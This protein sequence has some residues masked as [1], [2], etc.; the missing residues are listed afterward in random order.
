MNSPA[1]SDRPAC[2]FP[3][4]LHGG[5]YN[6]EQWLDDPGVLAEDFPLMRE[7][8]LSAVTLGVFSWAS[9]EPGEGVF[10][11]GW[12]DE[13]FRRANRHGM[14]VILAT[15]SGGKPNWLALQHEEVR[16][17]TL[18]GRRDPQRGRHNHCLTSPV[19]RRHVR[20]MN[21]RLAERYG[22]D[23]ALALWHVS[24]EYLG[25]C[26]C[27][28]CFAGF[29]E[30]L[31]RRYGS[32]DR[33]NHAYWARFWSHTFTDWEQIRHIDLSIH[34]LS[35]DWKRY[36][37]DLCADFFRAEAEP[38]RALTPH[39]PLTTNFHGIDHYDYFRLAREIDI[40]SWD[41]YPRW[42]ADPST[43]DE[44]AT[45]AEAAFRFDLN[46]C[47]KGGRP[48]LL[49]ECT[50]S[51]LNWQSVSPLRRPG[52]H[53]LS[54]L[55]AVAHGADAVCYFQIRKSRGGSE[56]FHGAV[57]DHAGGTGT[58]TF[59]EV[60]SVGTALQKLGAIAGSRIPARVAIVFDWENF[61]ALEQAET[62]QNAHKDYR[63]TCL[64]HH[65]PF[66]KMGIAVDVIGAGA[67]LS[68]YD[69]VILPMLY[70]LPRGLDE[71]LSA[72]VGQGGT[73]VAT[74]Q[75]G[76]VDETDLCFLGGVPGPLASLLGIWVEEFDALP[77]GVTRAVSPVPGAPS[78][79]S[80][81]YEARHYL[82]IVHPRG[83]E[84][85]ATYGDDFYAGFPALTR[86]TQGKGQAWYIASRNDNRFQDDFYRHLAD[87]L[88]L[89][90][91]VPGAL[92]PGVTAHLREKDGA[93][94]LF[95]LN[96]TLHE[97]RV[98]LPEGRWTEIET[99]RP[100]PPEVALPGYASRV[101]HQE[102]A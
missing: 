21:T 79:L 59:R 96:F 60:A 9:L 73:L 91:A 76:Y 71:R 87:E 36:M 56:K 12:L 45:A 3:G 34:G 4:L 41:S 98:S 75:T 37:T 53:R 74:Y 35:L 85:L 88:A 31:Q 18:D 11:F 48:F 69:L 80:G 6:P 27:D 24:N 5:D 25:Y 49:M 14:K 8:G 55:Q 86:H 77:D 7:A 97:A 83:A 68:S 20:A 100:A 51:Q 54:C 90:R 29:R 26:Y 102:T 22:S 58:R 43:F 93:R 78:G 13:V 66:G 92:P 70:L 99:A 15:P 62:P 47:L 39:I 10:S 61:W 50:P 28:L 2:T 63:A 84:T 67:E 46:R 65:R 57:I 82:D 23:P 52:L 89:P 19:Y 101:F 32:L 16:R 42:H 81:P 33:L 72:F 17:V 94:F 95:L 64:A 1:K 40:A 38:L 44:S 30:W